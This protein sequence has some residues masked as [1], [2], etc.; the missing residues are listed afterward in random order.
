MEQTDRQLNKDDYRLIRAMR[1]QSPQAQLDPAFS[2]ALKQ[3]LR[4][5]YRETQNHVSEARVTMALYALLAT[6]VVAI[7]LLLTILIWL[8]NPQVKQNVNVTPAVDDDTNEV[9]TTDVKTLRAEFGSLINARDFEEMKE[10]MADEVSISVSG[11]ECCGTLLRYDAAGELAF[12]LDG[13]G[14]F[15]FTETRADLQLIAAQNPD[16]T[17]HR[18]GITEEGFVIGFALDDK[19]AVNSIVFAQYSSLVSP[20]LEMVLDSVLDQINALDG[21][22]LTQTVAAEVGYEQFGQDCCGLLIQEEAI[23]LL[24][25]DARNGRPYTYDDGEQLS[26]SI[27]RYPVLEQFVLLLGSDGTIIGLQLNSDNRISEIITL[28]VRDVTAVTPDECSADSQLSQSGA[29]AYAAGSPSQLGPV[30][31][32]RYDA[33]SSDAAAG[34]YYFTIIGREVAAIS[35]ADGGIAWTIKGIPFTE[36]AK[37]ASDD[38]YIYVSTDRD[39][40]AFFADTRKLAWGRTLNWN[41]RF[42]PVSPVISCG[43]VILPVATPDRSSYTLEAFD[44][45]SGDRTWSQTLQGVVAVQPVTAGNGRI[46]VAD[47]PGNLYAFSALD[48]SIAWRTAARLQ[49]PATLTVTGSEVLMTQNGTLTVLEAESGRKR[50]GI[51]SPATDFVDVA[52]QGDRIYLLADN[53][54]STIISLADGE[55]LRRTSHQGLE[56]YIQIGGRFVLITDSSVHLADENLDSIRQIPLK[57]GVSTASPLYINGVLI[58]SAGDNYYGVTVR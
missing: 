27:S 58:F 38:T 2:A 18:F 35:P 40:F 3:Q 57:A 47:E 4:E 46:L 25:D 49:E 22:A 26:E 50:F 55:D 30:W 45:E 23:S 54:A 13:R 36:T 56:R 5:Q 19:F 39:L 52:V 10:Y 8:G 1:R 51:S 41:G 20:D 48:G 53:G 29:A 16:L 21:T 32:S 9:S 15:D 33:T 14:S 44:R 11:T 31:E 37:L 43:S 34:D 12:Q 6:F 42:A 24:L 28:N 7:P 17:K